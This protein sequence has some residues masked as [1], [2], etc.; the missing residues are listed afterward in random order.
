MTMMVFHMTKTMTTTETESLTTWKR[1][2][3][4][5]DGVPDCIEDADG[6]GIQDYHRNEFSMTSLHFRCKS[7]LC[8]GEK[9][10]GQTKLS[11]AAA[12]TQPSLQ[13]VE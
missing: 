2:R 9:N 13:A 3:T 1:T 6:D 4:V 5:I 8:F 11:S 12:A 7:F 10:S